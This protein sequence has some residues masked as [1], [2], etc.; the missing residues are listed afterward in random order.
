MKNT[1]LGVF[2]NHTA[3]ESALNELKAFGVNESDLSYVYKNNN[4][5]LKDGQSSNKVG[6]GTAAGVTAGAVIGGI[7]GLIVANVAL[8]GIGTLLVAGPLGA[9]LGISTA[10][11]TAVAGA[12]TGAAAGGLIGALKN[13]GVADADVHLYEDHVRQGDILVIARN[14]PASTKNIFVQE[15]AVDVREYTIN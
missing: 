13:M 2:I 5:D 7:A 1:T 15:G 8:P 3:A 6:E 9:A 12:A 4:G 11:A 14:T 10:A